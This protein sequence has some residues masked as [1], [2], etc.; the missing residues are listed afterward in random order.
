MQIGGMDPVNIPKRGMGQITHT[1][2]D[3]TA[4]EKRVEKLEADLRMYKMLLIA[5][6]VIYLLTS[7]K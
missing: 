3:F 1:D 5:A 4:L 7:K 2:L 6:V